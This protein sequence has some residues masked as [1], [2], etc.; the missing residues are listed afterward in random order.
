MT[1]SLPDSCKYDT[2]WF[3][4]KFR[5]VS[6]LRKTLGD[7][8]IIFSETY[9]TKKEEEDVPEE[10]TKD[11]GSEEESTSKESEGTEEVD[12]S[13]EEAPPAPPEEKSSES[14]DE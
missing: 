4:V 3:E 10:G 12:A 13:A 14:D 2:K 5:V 6:D 9:V 1:I 7:I 11:E 8:D